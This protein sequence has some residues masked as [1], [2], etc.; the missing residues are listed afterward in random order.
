MCHRLHIKRLLHDNLRDNDVL[1][2]YFRTFFTGSFVFR[3]YSIRSV[4]HDGRH[5][6]FKFN[7]L[8][9][10]NSYDNIQAVI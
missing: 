10:S 1:A 4:C 8:H 2:V 5:F 7:H 3:V 6:V 9:T